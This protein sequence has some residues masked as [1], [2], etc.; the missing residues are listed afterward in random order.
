MSEIVITG[1]GLSA[2]IASR[3]AE[4]QWLRDADGRDLLW[5]GDPAFWS[6][7][8]PILFPIV[9]RAANDVIRVDGIA[10]SLPQHGFARRRDFTLAAHEAGA[11]TFRLTADAATRAVYPFDFTLE[12]AFAIEGAALT[13]AAMLANP[14]DAPLPASFGYHPAL[15]WPLPY[16]RPR[17]AHRMV[18]TEDEAAPIRCIDADA[19]I[20][21]DV[22]PSPLDGR[23]LMLDDALFADGALIWDRLASR[24]VTFGA[25]GG[26]AIE[27]R[28]DGLTELGL[29]TRPGAGFVCIEPWAGHAD[30]AGFTG[31]LSDKPGIVVVPPGGRRFFTMQIA[32]VPEMPPP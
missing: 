20:R 25:P 4:L 22:R 28:Y 7:R 17:A 18:F 19:L 1:A 32:L 3:G 10:Y 29:W 15:R 24:G 12:I 21:P 6:G 13:V 30:P 23:T 11:A 5:D 27:L 16:D 8:A 26:P 14:G 2:A 31:E 9:G